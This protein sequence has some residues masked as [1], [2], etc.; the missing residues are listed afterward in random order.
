MG[1]ADNSREPSNR[2]QPMAKTLDHTHT[3]RQIDKGDALLSCLTDIHA[4]LL[5]SCAGDQIE[6]AAHDAVTVLEACTPQG[7]N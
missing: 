5:L 4:I 3:A 2:G 7:F 6:Q 1:T